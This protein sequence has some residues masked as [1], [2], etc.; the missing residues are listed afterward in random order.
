METLF[1]MAIALK[2]PFDLNYSL[3]SKIVDFQH[4][5]SNADLTHAESPV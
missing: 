5:P 4:W 2:F 1:A 3:A